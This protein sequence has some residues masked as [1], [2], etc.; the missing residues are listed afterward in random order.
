MNSMNESKVKQYISERQHCRE[1]A[2]MFD[3]I[4]HKSVRWWTCGLVWKV[5]WRVEQVCCCIM[6]PQGVDGYSAGKAQWKSLRPWRTGHDQYK[7]CS[8]SF[9]EISSHLLL[10]WSSFQF[11]QVLSTIMASRLNYYLLHAILKNWSKLL[12]HLFRAPAHAP[13]SIHNL[14]KPIQ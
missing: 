7:S 8:I 9:K 13:Y 12:Q 14:G 4:E 3:D 1:A 5:C 2:N 10:Y 6:T 11:P